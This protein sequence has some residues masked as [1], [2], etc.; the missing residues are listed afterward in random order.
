ME[1]PLIK[2]ELTQLEQIG[3][4]DGVI[5]GVIV[6]VLVGVFVGVGVIVQEPPGVIVPN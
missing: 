2:N 6:G 4:D 5:V 3:V 1:L